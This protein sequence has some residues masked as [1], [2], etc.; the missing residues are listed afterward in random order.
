MAVGT[1]LAGG[2]DMLEVGTEVKVTAEH[3]THLGETGLIIEVEEPHFLWGDM[4]RL[5][6]PDGK[7][8]AFSAYE[9]EEI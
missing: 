6:F 5:E 7:V 4:Y 9:V 2:D 8:L 1:S 3:S